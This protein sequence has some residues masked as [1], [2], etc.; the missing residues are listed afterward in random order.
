MSH[1]F[2]Q[3][4]TVLV[5]GSTDGI[6][7]QT[8]LE[9][10]RRGGRVVLHGRSEERLHS[11]MLQLRRADAD[12][13]GAVTGD[14]ASFASVRRMA[15]EVRT[16]FPELSVLVNNAGVYMSDHAMTEDGHE[17]TWQVNHL[18]MLLLTEQLLLVLKDN[19]PAR[20]VNVASIA[21][22]RGSIDFENLNG[23]REYDPYG[24]YAQSKLANIL[25]TYEL[26]AK[27]H[28]SGITVNCLHPGVIGT[29]LLREG[30]GIDGASVEEG[31]ATSVYLATSD[32]VADI[33]GKYFV[34]KQQTPSS[35]TS[36]DLELM[37][38]VWDVSEE[39]VQRESG[40]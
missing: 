5:T 10:A 24:A 6:G 15:A 35:A 7:L 1:T 29:K 17:M 2:I 39:Q 36:Y 19:L 23:E 32:E 38:R 3:D 21:H 8:A 16:S 12:I 28:G 34:R 20:I 37:R 9:I 14:F 33:S 13:A 40:R 4:R 30:F 31:A 25:F 11:A 22:T 26:A 27:L 18:S